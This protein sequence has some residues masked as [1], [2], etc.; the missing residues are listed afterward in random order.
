MKTSQ[1]LLADAKSASNKISKLESQKDKINKKHDTEKNKI[2]FA[3]SD[4]KSVIE[5]K[6]TAQRSKLEDENE[7]TN[8][9]YN[10]SI[11]GLHV[12]VTDVKKTV[13]F[14]K[15]AKKENPFD[16][17]LLKNYERYNQK[18]QVSRLYAQNDEFLKLSYVVYDANR[19]KNKIALCIVGHSMIGSHD[20]SNLEGKILDLPYSYGCHLRDDGHANIIHMVKHVP[21]IED[22]KKYAKNN[23]IEKVLKTFLKKY[24][25][26]KQECIETNKNYDLK[27]FEEYRLDETKKYFENNSRLLSHYTERLGIKKDVWEKLTMKEK[28]IILEDM[29]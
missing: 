22:A 18:S 5:K 13:Y 9:T 21:T 8:N 15:A 1:K 23:P 7:L 25:I 2:Y 14:L 19:P 12:L 24:E 28:R 3:E 29:A 17:G 27:D 4:E 20:S 26:V 10:N 6:Y 16:A 11:E